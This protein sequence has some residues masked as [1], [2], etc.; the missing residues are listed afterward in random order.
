MASSD[1][2]R[3]RQRL[4]RHG[5]Q[6]GPRRRSI[7]FF[8]DDAVYHNIPLDPIIGRDAIR[9]ALDGLPRHARDDDVRDAARARR[10]ADR[11]H[12]AGRQLHHRAT[13]PSR[14]RWPASSRCATARS[15]PGATT[16]T[17]ASSP[18][19]WRADAVRG[20]EGKV[21]IVTGGGNGIG[22]ATCRRFAEEGMSVVVADLLEESAAKTVA[23]CE[24][25]GGAGDRGR[26]R[27]VGP[28]RQRRH[29]RRGGRGLRR[30]RRARHRG[31]DPV[32]GL[33]QRR[34]GAARAHAR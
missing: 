29:R 33:P 7:G 22:A 24:E 8:S 6:A 15:P 11:R 26:R 12:R 1:A 14:C 25:L 27:R 28:G 34:A 30:G 13:A 18:T 4:L 10:R 20:L 19:R 16:S 32:L 9:E 17:W 2:A 21:A 5:Q 3:G 31:R 23:S